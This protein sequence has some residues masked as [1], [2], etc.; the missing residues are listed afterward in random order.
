MLERKKLFGTRLQFLF[1][2]NFI[3][4]ILTFSVCECITNGKHNV[5][6]VV[7]QFIFYLLLTEIYSEYIILSMRISYFFFNVAVDGKGFRIAG[8]IQLEIFISLNTQFSL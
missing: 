5:N 8:R 4:S 6:I 1:I 2:V 7:V 3:Q